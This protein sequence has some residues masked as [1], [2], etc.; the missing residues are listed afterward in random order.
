MEKLK[1]L[2]NLQVQLTVTRCH[3][4]HWCKLHLACFAI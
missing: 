1:L 4:T 2:V 3:L